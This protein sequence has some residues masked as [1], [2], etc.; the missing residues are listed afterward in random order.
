MGTTRIR[1]LG[2]ASIV[3]VLLTGCAATDQPP[4]T[5]GHATTG[6]ATATT[7]TGPTTGSTGRAGHAR[8]LSA[9]RSGAPTAAP[10]P[11]AHTT[12]P[13]PRP[14][15]SMPS[16][17][18]TSMGAQAGVCSTSGLTL[19]AGPTSHAAGSSYT[20]F[21]LTN[22]TDRTCTLQGY[23]GVSLL[24]THGHLV[25]RPATRTGPPG[26][27]I[28][29]PAGHD[30]TFTVDANSATQTG[31]P[32]PHPAARIRV[33]PPNQSTAITIAFPTTFCT[34]TVTTVSR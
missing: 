1:Q 7:S 16:P 31:C 24:D 11:V 23:P 32:V 29:I 13:T 26:P 2:T 34:L 6:T 15:E 3:A 14:S 22:T 19:T 9:T 18:P 27:V 30:A 5:S 33:Y 28:R 10:L 21:H 12:R 20:P 25:G 8:A 17:T 4:R